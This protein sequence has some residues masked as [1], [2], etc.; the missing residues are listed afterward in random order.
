MPVTLKDIA[1]RTGLSLPTISHILSGRDT[2]YRATTRQKVLAAAEALGYRTNLSARAIRTGSFGNLALLM[3]SNPGRS[4][5]FPALLDG[6]QSALDEHQLHLTISRLPDEKLTDP[7]FVPGIL[8]T[9]MADGMLI[10]YNSEIPRRLVALI[11]RFQIPSIWINV[12]MPHDAVY[13]DE[14]AAAEYA[15]RLVLKT[16]PGPVFFAD[17]TYG[18]DQQDA[19]FSV[20]DRHAGYLAAMKRAGREAGRLGLASRLERKDRVAFTETWLAGRKPPFGLVCISSSTAL[21]ICHAAAL[22]GW[23]AGRD[24]S[25]VTFGEALVDLGG[26]AIDTMVVPMFDLGRSAVEMLLAKIATPQLLPSRPIPLLHAQGSTLPQRTSGPRR[27][28]RHA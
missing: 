5:L 25:M 10:L 23:Q 2:A 11:E 28:V 1:A 17:F 15:T 9:W 8:R 7:G 24:F 13:P 27:K 6:I 26:I 21:P 3:S 14:R 19:H 4:G 18:L 20:R 12:D 16:Q 22:H